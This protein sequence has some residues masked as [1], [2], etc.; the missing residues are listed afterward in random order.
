MGTL[1]VSASRF[2]AHIS[3]CIPLQRLSHR[4]WCTLRNGFTSRKILS[5]NYLFQVPFCLSS[6]FT[7]IAVQPWLHSEF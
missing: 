2:E 4:P 6:L 5:T 1:T 3:Y 7:L